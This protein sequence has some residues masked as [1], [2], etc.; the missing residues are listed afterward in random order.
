M[1]QEKDATLTTLGVPMRRDLKCFSLFV[2][3]SGVVLAA[4]GSPTEELEFVPDDP[5]STQ[6]SALCSGA[7][8]SSLTLL[9]VSSWQGEL[10]SSGDWEV[11]G[12]ANAARLEYLVDGVMRAF[13]ERVGL[14]GNWFFSTQGISCGT[15]S[16]LVKAYPMIID[17]VGNRT[18]CSMNTPSIQ[19]AS[20][21]DTSCMCVIGNIAYSNG[22]VNPANACQICDIAQSTTSWSHNGAGIISSAGYCKPFLDGRQICVNNPLKNGL[23]CTTRSECYTTCDDLI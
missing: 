6:R 1:G 2:W 16:F 22:R 7:S 8:V 11:Q 4:C 20:F 18:T 12:G 10:G 15:H 3:V 17:S 5:L 9:G 14:S 21:R 23:S 13:D 19:S